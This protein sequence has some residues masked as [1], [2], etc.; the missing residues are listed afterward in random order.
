MNES[1]CIQYYN[2][3]LAQISLYLV[4]FRI[5][6]LNLSHE[7]FVYIHKSMGTGT[8]FER[9]GMMFKINGEKNMFQQY[10]GSAGLP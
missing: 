3:V 8:Q 6:S 2:Y 5:D 10:H 9:Y 7:L 4:I 1:L